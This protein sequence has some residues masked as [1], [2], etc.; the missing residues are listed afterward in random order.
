MERPTAPLSQFVTS[1]AVRRFTDVSFPSRVEVGKR[2]HLRVRIARIQQHAHDAAL[3]LEF[4]PSVASLPV[5]VDVAT[6]NFTIQS[7]PQATLHVPRE[8]DSTGIQFSLVGN[9]IGPGR[10]MI[11]F[12]QEGRPL[13]SVDLSVAVASGTFDSATVS[14]RRSE[15]RLH[16]GAHDPLHVT[17]YV[18]ECWSCPG[19]LQFFLCSRYPRL[20]DLPFVNHG[21][22]GFIDLRQSTFDWVERQLDVINRCGSPEDNRHLADLG[23]RLYDQVLPEKLQQL[24]WSLAERSVK[25]VLMVSDEPHIPWELIRPHRQNPTTGLPEELPF[26]GESFALGRW[27]RG[28]G[29]P[30]RFSL[31][32]ICA[33]FQR[34]RLQPASS[35]AFLGT[36][37]QPLTRRRV[38]SKQCI[39]RHCGVHRRSYRRC[40]S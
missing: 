18:Y 5:T 40:W 22:L 3:D 13:G 8:G 32:R 37:S 35:A 24:C 2:T 25:T 7:A 17:V 20:Q 1:T 14:S 34:G 28:P 31:R 38:P 29:M 39:P 26:W 33:V 4:P 30:E 9:Q 19:R 21:D 12:S 10:V 36:S 23:N 16:T 6:E 15:V 11:D 27:L